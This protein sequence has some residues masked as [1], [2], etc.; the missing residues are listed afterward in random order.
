MLTMSTKL[1]HASGLARVDELYQDRPQRAKELR[2]EGKKVIG[3]SPL[4]TWFRIVFRAI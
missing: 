4:W 2:K 1:A 3:C